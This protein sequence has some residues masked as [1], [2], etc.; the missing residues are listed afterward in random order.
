MW[1]EREQILEAGFVLTGVGFVAGFILLV[2]G[3]LAE[4]RRREHLFVEPAPPLSSIPAER[5]QHLAP[6]P[7]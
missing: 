6:S 4:N 5:H 1:L 2:A 7:R 3:R